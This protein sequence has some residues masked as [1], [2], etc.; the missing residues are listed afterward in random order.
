MRGGW[1]RPPVTSS[2]AE[3]QTLCFVFRHDELLVLKRRYP[4]N[5]GLWNCPGGKVEVGEGPTEACVREVLEETGL[6]ILDPQLR[7]VIASPSSKRGINTTVVFVF[8]ST[9]FV[10]E[11]RDSREG[12]I[13]WLP[14]KY[15][16]LEPEIS[17]DLPVLYKCISESAGVVTGKWAPIESDTA[18][19]IVLDR[20]APVF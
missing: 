10:G 11:V 12:L 7:A 4:P 18:A 3:L 14:L 1:G 15:L 17:P 13:D 20:V 19:H 9:Q 16:T 8:E 2:R 5:A 6:Q